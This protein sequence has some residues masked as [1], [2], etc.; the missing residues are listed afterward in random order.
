MEKPAAD[1]H[2]TDP[3]TLRALLVAGAAP[4]GRPAA[5][6]AGERGA[7]AGHRGRARGRARRS[8]SAT[9]TTRSRSGPPPLRVLADPDAAGRHLHRRAAAGAPGGG[10]PAGRDDRARRAR[11]G[12]GGAAGRA[13]G[14]GRPGGAHRSGGGHPPR[15]T[16]DPT[17]TAPAT[18]RRPRRPRHAGGRGAHRRRRRP[19]LNHDSRVGPV[20]TSGREF[21]NASGTC[22]SLT[23]PTRSAYSARCLRVSAGPKTL[24][25]D[26]SAGRKARHIGHG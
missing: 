26:L 17:A 25:H 16:T 10:R 8:S 3:R 18:T 12:G 2:V 24:N 6:R 7:R 13:V 1:G 11:G 21:V 20:S 15:P 23:Y 9:P 22:R 14:P 19:A 4:G 5:D